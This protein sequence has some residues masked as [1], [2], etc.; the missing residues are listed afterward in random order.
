MTTS[1]CLRA[2]AL[3]L[4]APLPLYAQSPDAGRVHRIGYISPTGPSPSYEALRQGLK[5]A[6]YVEGRNLVIETRW[7]D[8]KAERLP[9]LADEL[10]QAKVDV[11]V[12]G[13]TVGTRALQ[14]ATTT[15]PIVFAGLSDPVTAGVLKDLRQPEGNT[16][17]VLQGPGNAEFAGRWVD[18]VKEVAPGASRIAVLSAPSAPVTAA[19][20]EQVQ[21]AAKAAGVSLDVHD[22]HDPAAMDAAFAKIG[23]SGAHGLIVIPDPFF[24]NSRA[25]IA[26]FA[27]EKRLPSV[28]FTNVLADAGTLMSYGG[29]LEAANRRAAGHVDRILKGAKPADL[30]I[31]AMPVELVVNLKTARALGITVPESLVKR[32]DRVID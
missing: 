8:N 1:T 25:R 21:R 32:A 17:G 24:N 15:M 2:L 18:L 5:D 31:V 23:A 16:T 14:K 6:G 30:P 29:S 10:V 13:S 28:G 19:F 7:A 11:L 20:I 27:T 12:A 9:Q 4:L 3:L 22:A 26:Q